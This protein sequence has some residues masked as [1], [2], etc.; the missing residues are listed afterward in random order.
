MWKE[1]SV[2]SERIKMMSE[3]ESGEDTISELAEY[4]GVSRKTVYKWVE[5]FEALGWQGLK[6]QSRAPHSHPNAIGADIERQ[7]LELKASKPLWGAPKLRHKLL[8]RVGPEHCPAESTISEILRRHGLS[9]R[10]KPKARAVPSKQPLAHCQQANQVWSA[11]FKGWFRTGNGQ[12]CTPLTISDGHSRYLLCCQ[13]LGEA[14]G[15]A[16]V[17]P[18]FIQTFREYGMPGAIRTDN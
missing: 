11:D 7:L 8:G 2:M 4:Y 13:G 6:E 16:S 5:R 3:Y 10:L 9:A 12:K 18:L 17:K 15:H 1:N 14:T